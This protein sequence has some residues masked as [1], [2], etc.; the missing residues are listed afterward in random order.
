MLVFLKAERHAKFKCGFQSEIR[1]TKILQQIFFVKR[2]L[3][4]LLNL[5]VNSNVSNLGRS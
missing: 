5:V 3:N 4:L 1:P 2:R